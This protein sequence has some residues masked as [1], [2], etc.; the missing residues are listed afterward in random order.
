MFRRDDWQVRAETS[1]VLTSDSK[2]FYV[3]ATLD[4]YEGEK[5]I[6]SRNWDLE[7]P[8]RNV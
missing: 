7:I 3:I 8:R 2:N 1:T 4:A 6:F 5:R